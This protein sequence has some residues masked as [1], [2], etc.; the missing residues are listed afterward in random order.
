MAI[1]QVRVADTA[2]PVRCLRRHHEVQRAPQ[3]GPAK[4]I[5]KGERWI[6]C[7]CGCAVIRIRANTEIRVS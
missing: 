7:G 1:R 4:A 3:K 6:G 2:M 5:E